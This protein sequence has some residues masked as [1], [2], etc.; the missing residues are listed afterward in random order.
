M[1]GCLNYRKPTDSERWIYV[2][3]GKS[4]EVEAIGHFRLLLCTG[5]YLD[6]KDTFVV[7]SFRQNLILVSYL[8]K[9]GYSCSFGNN[10]FSL[11]FNSNIVETGS[12]LAYDNLY[13]LDTVTTYNE[14]FNTE[15]HGTKCKI[16]NTQS[17]TLWHKRLGHISKNRVE[18]LVSNGILESI[19]FTNFVICVECIKGKQTKAKRLGAYRASDVLELIHTDICGSFP[20]PS[21]NGQQYFI[22]F[23]DDYSR[24]AYLFLIHEKSQ[25][26]DVFKSFKVEVENQLNKR[27]KSV[28]SDRGGEYYGRYDGSG[29]QR[30]GPFAK[31]LEECGIVPQYTM[32]GSPSM[33]GVAEM[34][35]I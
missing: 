3:D 23:I 13:L 29:E 6:L 14:T 18:R 1:K 10:E 5:F 4:V 19:D 11:S 15:S 30:P 17:G 35:R 9:S 21:W 24:Y 25:S 34:I 20:T 27:I 26:L 7:L 8:D 32:L 33:N 16:D 22:S 12:L 31:Y 28:R 2:R